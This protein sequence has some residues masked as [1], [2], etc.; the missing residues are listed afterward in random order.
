MLRERTEKKRSEVVHRWLETDRRDILVLG[1]EEDVGNAAKKAHR[2]RQR[3]R[4]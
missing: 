2:Q 3:Y 1:K 4:L